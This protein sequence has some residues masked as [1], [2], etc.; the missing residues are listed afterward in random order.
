[1]KDLASGKEWPGFGSALSK[2]EFDVFQNLIETHHHY[3]GWFTTDNIRRALF[4]WSDALSEANLTKWLGA[5]DLEDPADKKK[6]AIICA[7]NIPMVG[8]HDVLTVLITGHVAYIKLSSDDNKLIPA[9]LNIYAKLNPAGSS[10]YVMAEQKLSGHQAVIATGSNNTSRYFDYYFRDIPHIIRR[11]RTSV[12]I[13]RGK[14]TAEELVQLG[15]DIFDYFGLGCRNVSKV[16]LPEGYDIN[17]MIEAIYNFHPIINHNK[18]AN[19]Y[20][21][22]KAVWLLNRENLLDNGFLLFRK[23]DDGF[24]SPT[25]SLYYQYYS[26]ETQLKEMLAERTEELQCIVGKQEIPFGKSQSPQ[27]WDYAD[28]VDTLSFLSALNGRD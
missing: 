2:D 9:I 23:D 16:F 25:G 28:H 11:S 14:E 18:Y 1:M 4:A 21:Y 7:G 8:F 5:Y 26:D 17:K 10:D 22:N 20:D 27:L 15:H 12:A 6:V 24:A 13:L 3:N 19:N